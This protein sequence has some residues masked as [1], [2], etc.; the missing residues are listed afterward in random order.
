MISHIS[1]TLLD[2]YMNWRISSV[3][4]VERMRMIDVRE[5]IGTEA[6][7]VG[8]IKPDEM[9]GMKDERLPKISETKKHKGCRKRGRPQ[10]RCED[11]VK[12]SRKSRGGRK[13]REKDIDRE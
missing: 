1:F 8:K 2:T 12:R 5:E 4:R 9:V 6:R 10:L 13:W 3:K 7:K 11:C